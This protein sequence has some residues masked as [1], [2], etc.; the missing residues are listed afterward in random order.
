LAQGRDNP[1]V[2][3]DYRFGVVLSAV[4]VL[5]GLSTNGYPSAVR[6]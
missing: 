1:T 5:T 6:T 3:P 4:S 2:I